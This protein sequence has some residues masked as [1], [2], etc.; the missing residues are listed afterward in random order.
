MHEG[1][2]VYAKKNKIVS[3]PFVKVLLEQNPS[4]FGCAIVQ[5]GE[6]LTALDKDPVTAETMDKSIESVISIM[7]DHKEKDRVMFFGKY[8]DTY[9]EDDLQPYVIL[10]NSKDEMVTVAFMEGLFPKYHD[11]SSKHSDAFL[12]AFKHLLPTLFDRYA[13]CNEDLSKFS[14]GLSDLHI[15]ITMENMIGERG[16]I[17]LFLATGEIVAYKRPDDLNYREFDWGWTSRHFNYKESEFPLK[18]VADQGR[19]IFGKQSSGVKSTVAPP[20]STPAG[21][22]SVPQVKRPDPLASTSQIPVTPAVG[23]P[24]WVR[25]PPQYTVKH[26]SQVKKHFKDFINACPGNWRDLPIVQVTAPLYLKN[27]ELIPKELIVPA[28]VGSMATEKAT[29]TNLAT[30]AK[31][32]ATV[33]EEKVPQV[34]GTS[35]IMSPDTLIGVTEFLKR[36]DIQEKIEQRKLTIKAQGSAEM[37]ID[38][39]EIQIQEEKNPTFSQQ[40][41][42]DLDDTATWTV[43]QCITMAKEIEKKGGAYSAYRALSILLCN[44]KAHD[45]L[46]RPIPKKTTAE[47]PK[48]AK[49]FGQAH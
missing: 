5:N 3:E 31:T 36:K 17:T 40:A 18:V 42:I 38:P 47:A 25:V 12:C 43:E 37:L 1:T 32:V 27:P 49:R 48:P 28:P 2:I 10:R 39:K 14:K 45:L 9:L 41:G 29:A 13:A 7:N 46:H 20:P 30:G 11:P 4:C 26:K 24:V 23:T 35:T 19:K 8:P 15:Q 34:V 22:H 21:V 33:G 6:I 44:W 16:M